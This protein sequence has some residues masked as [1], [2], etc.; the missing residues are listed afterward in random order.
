M[1]LPNPLPSVGAK[2]KITGAY[3]VAKTVVSDM[4]S[5]PMGGVMV[6][7]KMDVIDPSPEPAKFAKP[8]P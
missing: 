3:N 6:L 1:A 4:V 7:Q 2:V 5:E 8:I